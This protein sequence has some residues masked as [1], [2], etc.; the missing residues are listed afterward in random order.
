MNEPD[1]AWRGAIDDF[2]IYGQALTASQLRELFDAQGDANHDGENNWT[3]YLH[4]EDPR[5]GAGGPSSEGSLDLRFVPLDWSPYED[6]QYL[7]RFR[8]GNPGG[9]IHLYVENDT[10]TFL[11]LDADGDRHYIQ[12]RDL[13][14]GGYL[15]PGAT[16]RIT[17]SWRGFNSGRT[18][19]EMRLYVNGLDYQE[20]TRLLYN[21][22]LTSYDWEQGGSYWN[23]AFM[24]ADWGTVVSSN[25]TRFGSWA[26]GLFTAK[27]V[28]V[29]THVHPTA[30]GMVSTDPQP[31]F[32]AGFKTAPARGSR[33]V[34]LIQG[35]SQPRVMADFVSSNE[36]RVLIR[37]YGQVADAAE[38]TMNWLAWGGLSSSVWGVM[39]DNIRNSIDVGN[40]EGFAVALSSWIHLDAKICRKYSQSIP[41]RAQRLQVVTNGFEARI[42]LTNAAWTGEDGLP[43]EAK[44]DY[45]HRETVSQYL[46]R[47]KED[48]SQYSNYSYFFFNEDA[49]L[50]F[51]EASYLHSPTYSTNGLA[52]FREYVVAKYGPEY[53]Q[54]RFPVHPLAIGLL[55]G[56]NETAFT[57]TLDSSVTNRVEFTTDPA[58]WS[59]WW[60]WRQV[61]FAHLMDGY[62]RQLAG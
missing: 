8:D 37:R 40:Q 15:M 9:E 26:E 48:L 1:A 14:A 44:P 2:R 35:L 33:P 51:W 55:K 30:Y 31:T 61:V 41:A 59:K 58:H 18:N 17:A 25:H 57:V 34:V 12:H 56:S 27:V 50:P 29:E 42:V 38:K 39:E 49:L 53:T 10:L 22:R 60:E 32:E 19:A 24:K 62:A 5:L 20:T 6:P 28:W 46:A 47:W 52:W 16:N 7:A 4:G 36:M 23:A 13:V 45:G 3:A 21:P 54:I 11:L 43:V